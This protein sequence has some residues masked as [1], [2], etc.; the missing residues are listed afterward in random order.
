MPTK[1]F[2]SGG[3]GG[4]DGEVA[5][6]LRALANERRLMILC[7]LVEWGEG[8]V[9]SLAEAVGLSQSAL[10][11]HLAK[12]RDEGLVTFRRE[13]QTLWYRIADPRIEELFATL[14]R[15]YCKPRQSST[16]NHGVRHVA[17]HN[18]PGRSQASSGSRA[19]SWST[20]ARRTS[21]P[22]R[23][24]PGRRHLP[25]SKLDEADLALH[26]GQARHLP[27]QERGANHDQC[28]PARAANGRG[29]RSLH[30][31]GRAR[32]LEEGGIAGRD[33]S[34][35]A[36]RTAATSADRRGQL[37]HSS[38][39]CLGLWF[40]RGFLS[41]PAF[42]GAGLIMAGVTGFCGMARLLMRAPWNRAAYA[43]TAVRPRPPDGARDTRRFWSNRDGADLHRKACSRYRFGLRSSAS[44]SGWSAAAARSWRCR[45]WSMW[46]GLDN[47]HIAIGTSA[48]AV[49]LNAAANLAMHARAGNVK[50]RCAVVFAA[51]GVAGAFLG[52]TLGK[53]MD[54]QR[55]L[56]LF[57]VLMMV[58][59]ALM[60]RGRAR[61][62]DPSV[63]L[64]AREP[65]EAAGAGPGG[66]VRCPGFFGIGGGF[67]IVPAP[68][69]GD[70]G[71]RS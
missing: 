64:I 11:Q 67:L 39:R 16:L 55:L 65:A 3:D 59:G 48:I 12:M 40:R 50:W 31:R 42:V 28:L 2:R 22:A 29:L 20:S 53:M 37:S 30:R 1:S 47:P 46:S 45:C 66:R 5:G 25:L 4:R 62:G 15:L 71:C 13:S 24:S 38:G 6:I 52:S 54:G 41:V 14:H 27:L 61:V 43:P 18:Q 35:P 36:N 33:R 58:V 49:A 9:N 56:A 51:A 70:A 10:S 7:K 21:M 23:R 8:N 57:A 19:P 60:L 68:D 34:P 32:C 44:R 17:S 63:R 26:A 69:A